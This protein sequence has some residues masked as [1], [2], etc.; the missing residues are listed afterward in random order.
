M[1]DSDFKYIFESVGCEWL[2]KLAGKTVL[3]VGGSGFLGTCYKNF[4]IY[5]NNQNIGYYS[6]EVG[7]GFK[8]KPPTKI[9]SIDNYLKGTTTLNDETQHE[10]LT[11]FNHDI[12]A[13]LGSKL[14][15]TKIDYIINCSG[16]ASP[17]GYAKYPLETMDVST[18]GTRNLFDLAVANKASILNF[19]SSEVLGT[20]PE[21]EIPTTEESIARIHSFN[22]RAPYDTTKL[23]IETVSWVFKTKYNVDAKVIRPFNIISDTMSQND[24][25]VIPNYLGKILRNQSI[26]VYSPGTQTRTFCWWTDF[27][28]GSLK[29]ILQGRELVYHIGNPYNEISMIDLANKVAAL[30]NRPDLVKLVPTPDVYQYEPK[31]RC[32]DIT[33]AKLELKYDPK[34]DLDQ[35]L[36]KAYDWAKLN[37]KLD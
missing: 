37:Y 10:H 18:I 21:N 3:L 15:N 16:M 14:Y 29:V 7:I 17:S 6:H 4:L 22:K 25:R 13:P 11:T 32:P 30:H 8:R 5:F 34:I 19:S 2:H 9:I 24:W 28:V 31:R 33:K 12:I 27:L 35:M 20:P 23:Y 36:I 26:D 1:T